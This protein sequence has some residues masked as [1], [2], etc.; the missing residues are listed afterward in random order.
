MDF[1]ASSNA[2][3]EPTATSK[4]NLN[5]KTMDSENN[6]KLWPL[7]LDLGFCL[8]GL[9]WLSTISL[10]SAHCYQDNGKA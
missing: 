6:L 8:T 7:A 5:P 10:R 1:R 2:A 9:E 4:P 3:D